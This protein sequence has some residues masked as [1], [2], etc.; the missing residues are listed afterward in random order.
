MLTLTNNLVSLGLFQNLNY[1]LL[2]SIIINIF[3]YIN[4]AP[5][6]VSF[7]QFIMCLSFVMEHYVK[8]KLNNINPI[9]VFS[10]TMLFTSY[11]HLI[12]F[13]NLDL[14]DSSFYQYFK[15]SVPKYY[16]EAMEIY[17]L[18]VLFIIVG[19]NL[20]KKN[21][22]K[23]FSIIGLIEQ[24]SVYKNLFYISLFLI[25]F[26]NVIPIPSALN[27]LIFT[28]PLL[29]MF[30]LNVIGFKYAIPVLKN[31]SLI[32]VLCL[33]IN[34][35]FNSFLR[36]EIISPIIIHVIS[37][38]IAQKNVKSIFS[39]KYIPIFILTTF[40]I[41]SFNKLGMIRTMYHL[42][43][44]ERLI[45]LLNGDEK[46]LGL[47]IEDEKKQS[48]L[49]RATVINQL[50]QLVKLKE[51]DGYYY[52]ETLAYLG[53]A[54][55]PR[56]IWPDKPIII[57]GSWFAEKIGLA[58]KNEQGR[59]NNSINMTIYGEAYLNFGYWGV[60]TICIAFGFFISKLWESSGEMKNYFNLAGIGFSLILISYGTFQLGA[61]I[62]IVVTLISIY[63]TFLA[64]SYI[65]T[66]LRN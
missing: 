48:V 1:L 8:H 38:L 50:T 44:E 57:Q 20:G 32:L 13:L 9:L 59:Y 10:V 56:I 47:E 25:F 65:V 26:P 66:A 4:D 42:T 17:Y 34:N 19:Y 24:I 45:F 31:Y 53:Y 64:L 23:L 40:F 61:D 33:T 30:L 3:G 27:K 5:V 51:Q 36:F 35:L 54:F 21:S 52:G 6:I 2:I 28:L 15:Y 37:T 49:S 14:K 39:V 18:G 22:V 43:K 11:G 62:Q 16:T 12:A 46:E 41:F 55:I 58:L 60:F 7:S 63:L 29:S